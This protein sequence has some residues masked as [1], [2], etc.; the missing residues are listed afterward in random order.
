M[1]GAQ[2]APALRRCSSKAC[3]AA[4]LQ[5]PVERGT[6]MASTTAPVPR[7]ASAPSGIEVIY[8]W[9]P[10]GG[11]LPEEEWRVRH[12]AISIVLWLQV[13]LLAVVGVVN[14]RPGTQVVGDVAAVALCGVLAVLPGRSTKTFFVSLGLL[15]SSAGLVHLTGGLTESHFHF[16]VMLGLV[17]LYQEWVPYLAAVA[18]VVL[19]HTIIGMVWPDAA[20]DAGPAQERPFLWAVVHAAF[21]LGQIAVQVTVW[22]FLELHQ[23]RLLARERR[24]VAAEHTL[25][26]ERERRVHL[27]DAV[28]QLSHWRDLERPEPP[29]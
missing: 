9:L 20:Y 27:E 28:Y 4:A 1:P 7:T 3:V 26:G 19:H 13:P 15:T 11:Q 12:R 14:E 17:A 22:K 5:S 18:Y 2:A 6:T 10:R 25:V 8:R 16:F 29:D 21:I 24:A 23:D